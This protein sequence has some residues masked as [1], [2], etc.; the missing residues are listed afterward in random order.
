MH[1]LE[2]QIKRLLLLVGIAGVMVIY[3]GFF[4]LLLSGRS[5][6][7]ITWYYLLSPWIC[8]FFGL[9]SLQQYRVLQWFCARYKK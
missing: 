6:E 5:T 8:I 3:F 9:S 7:P 1:W 2:K 4:Y